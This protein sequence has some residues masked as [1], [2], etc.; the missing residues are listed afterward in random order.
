LLGDHPF[1]DHLQRHRVTASTAVLE[2]IAITFPLIL[3]VVDGMI[4]VLSVKGNGELTKVDTVSLLC[5]A[6]GLLDLTDHARIHGSSLLLDGNIALD[7]R[8]IAKEHAKNCVLF[9]INS[10]GSG[11]LAS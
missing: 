8:L 10:Q 4:V 1:Q 5:V 6:F 9:I 2:E 3:A 11:G 7:Q